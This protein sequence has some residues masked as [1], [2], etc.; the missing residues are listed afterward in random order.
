[1]KRTLNAKEKTLIFIKHTKTKNLK[2]AGIILPILLIALVITTWMGRAEEVNTVASKSDQTLTMTMVGDVMMGRYVEKVTDK[3]GYDYLFRYMKPYFTA[4]DYV[5]GNYEHPALKEDVS[6]YKEA[7]T[8]IRLNS[9]QSGVEA[10]KNAGFSVMTLANNH[11]MDLKNKACLIQLM[12]SKMRIWIMS[13]LD[14]ILQMLKQVSIIQMLM[15]Y[16]WP[17]LASPMFMARMQYPK[18]IKL[19][20]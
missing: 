7:D 15:A 14:Q 17:L 8:A 12:N 3:H 16:V 5:S 1:M 18:I 20:Y 4:S 10:V 9:Y 2:Y 13:V 11:M 6:K 19:V